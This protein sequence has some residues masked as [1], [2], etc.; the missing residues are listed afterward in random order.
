MYNPDISVKTY[1]VVSLVFAALFAA[2]VV[3]I[4]SP[5]FNWIFGMVAI[6]TAFMAITQDWLDQR[7]ARA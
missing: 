4:G 2:S 5:V 1:L 3:L 6:A 7:A